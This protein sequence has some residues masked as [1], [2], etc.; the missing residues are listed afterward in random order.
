MKDF[1]PSKLFY[2][3]RVPTSSLFLSIFRLAAVST[4]LLP[5]QPSAP[6]R[7]VSA[8]ILA[9]QPVTRET[10]VA[11]ERRLERAAVPAPHRPDY[12][13]WT[14][15][16]L[17]FCHKY[18]HPPRSRTSLA[19]FLSELAGKNQSAEQR[20]QA[21]HA[22]RLLLGPARE[23]SVSPPVQA[24]EGRASAPATPRSQ[25]QPVPP[26]PVSSELRPTPPAQAAP[27]PPPPA[28]SL[29]GSADKAPATAPVPGHG[30]SWEKEYRDLEGSIKLRNYSP[31]TLAA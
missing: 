10:W 31:R 23:P 16:Y 19:P 7:A 3:C 2:P 15:F 25:N 1:A 11:F 24:A 17:D 28:A 13:K 29:A 14:R 27:P 6:G 18:G 12:H 20:N 8:T 9:M 26:C 30:A 4:P 5:C 22:I 21:A